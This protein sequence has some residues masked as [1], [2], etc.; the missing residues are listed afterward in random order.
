MSVPSSE[1]RMLRSCSY[2]DVLDGSENTP[3]P[4][5]IG[6]TSTADVNNNPGDYVVVK[7]ANGQLC[8]VKKST[9]SPRP[10][11][12]PVDTSSPVERFDVEKLKSVY[13]EKSKEDLIMDL[14]ERDR[15]VAHQSTELRRLNRL[16]AKHG[17]SNV[18][19]NS[20]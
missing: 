9:G 16:L 8:K 15:L 1:N 14:I 6:D 20:S 19:G 10:P 2:G 4:I 12:L 7:N 3:T 17:A 5:Y 18:I 13:I 11:F